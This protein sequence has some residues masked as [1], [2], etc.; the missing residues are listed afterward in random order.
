LKQLGC[1]LG[2]LGSGQLQKLCQ[3]FSAVGHINN[4]NAIAFLARLSIGAQ[5]AL[6]PPLLAR[7]DQSARGRGVRTMLKK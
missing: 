4:G 2:A 6:R 5:L 7:A 3:H 1:E